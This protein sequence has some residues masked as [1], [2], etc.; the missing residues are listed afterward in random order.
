MGK[1]FKRN[2]AHAFMRDIYPM[3]TNDSGVPSSVCLFPTRFLDVMCSVSSTYCSILWRFT[4]PAP[5]LL[6]SF[7]VSCSWL[8]RQS[9]SACAYLLYVT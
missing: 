2:M 5:G 7:P 8:V 1:D 3:E 9:F 6:V 4:R